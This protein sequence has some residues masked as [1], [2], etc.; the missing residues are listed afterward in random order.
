MTTDVAGTVVTETIEVAAGRDRAFHV[1]TAEM[2]TW[3]PA[4]HHIVEGELERMVVEPRAGGHIV[5]VATNG[6]EC[7][8][9]RVLAYEPPNR[10]VFSWDINLSWQIET[11][12]AKTSEVEVRFTAQGPDT[13]LVELEHRNIDRHGDGWEQMRDAVGSEGGWNL[14]RFAEVAAAG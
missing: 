7:R 6:N 12:P 5:D 1:F 14:E 4:E 3:W 2:D 8:W 11:D 10:L 13:T 9:A